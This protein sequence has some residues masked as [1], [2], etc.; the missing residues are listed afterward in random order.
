MLNGIHGQKLIAMAYGI[1]AK[2]K[3]LYFFKKKK[4]C[5]TFC[6]KKASRRLAC[7]DGIHNIVITLKN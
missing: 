2:R 7:R 1:L 5:I 3:I 4:I 6:K